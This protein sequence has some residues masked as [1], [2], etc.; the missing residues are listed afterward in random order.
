MNK[1][2]PLAIRLTGP[3]ARGIKLKARL[4]LARDKARARLGLG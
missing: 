2:N 4:G 3:R 1:V